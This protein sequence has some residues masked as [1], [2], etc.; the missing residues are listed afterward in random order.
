MKEFHCFGQCWLGDREG[1]QPVKNPAPAIAEKSS[2]EPGLR[3]S[4][5]WEKQTGR[6]NKN[7]KQL[8]VKENG[9]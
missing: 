3:R 6:L 8:H 2:L 1:I 9:R 7:R 4:N 5:L